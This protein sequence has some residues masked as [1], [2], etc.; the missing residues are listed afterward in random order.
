MVPELTE[1]LP[2]QAEQC[3]SVEL[4]VAADVIVGVRVQRLAMLAAPLLL[5]IIPAFYVDGSGV[6][7]LGFAPDVVA[8][9]EQQDTLTGGGESVG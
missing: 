7:V 3:R 5:R 2:P 6:P 9:L 8:A 4:G 1:I